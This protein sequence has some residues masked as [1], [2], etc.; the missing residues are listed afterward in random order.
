MPSSMERA[1]RFAHDVDVSSLDDG[2]FEVLAIVSFE[3][4]V[5]GACDVEGL[6]TLV[7]SR[8]FCKSFDTRV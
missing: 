1:F 3:G 8:C 2:E 4:F 5:A 7:F 6:L